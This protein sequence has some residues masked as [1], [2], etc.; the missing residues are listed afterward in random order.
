MLETAVQVV[1]ATEVSAGSQLM[2]ESIL[3]DGEE[4]FDKHLNGVV[5]CETLYRKLSAYWVP[6]V[7]HPTFL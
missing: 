6:G 2:L 4:V 5:D 7:V 3:K 1:P